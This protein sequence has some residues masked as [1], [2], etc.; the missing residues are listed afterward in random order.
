[1]SISYRRS[2]FC[3]VIAKD[4]FFIPYLAEKLNVTQFKCPILKVSIIFFIIEK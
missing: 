4:K 1:M 2:N 3:E